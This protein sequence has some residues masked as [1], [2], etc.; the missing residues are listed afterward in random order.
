MPAFVKI[1]HDDSIRRRISARLVASR[2]LRSMVARHVV[3]TEDAART[4]LEEHP[5]GKPV[6]MPGASPAPHQG[7]PVQLSRREQKLLHHIEEARKNPAF[8][9]ALTEIYSKP[10]PAVHKTQIQHVI[11]EHLGEGSEAHKAFE[12][13]HSEHDPE[14]RESL[15]H[16]VVE[17]VLHPVVHFGIEKAIESAVEQAAEGGMTAL[18]GVI[19]NAFGGPV[20]AIM[21][22]ATTRIL[23]SQIEHMIEKRHER[24]A[25]YDSFQRFISST[26]Q[27]TATGMHK[28]ELANAIET[29]LAGRLSK[30]VAHQFMQ[31]FGP[32]IVNM[33]QKYLREHVEELH[34]RKVN[35]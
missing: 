34:D 18:A 25:S 21:A 24:T 29:A 17:N 20:I 23:F 3:P 10:I 16:K 19:G 28:E 14:K 5:H 13:A 33:I 26:L 15:M 9:K 1:P 7:Q 32:H 4:Y 11:A 22:A 27:E 35:A 31:S 2:F 12:A 8:H 30:P 6:V